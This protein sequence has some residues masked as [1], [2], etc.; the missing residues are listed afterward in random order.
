M[1]NLL[2]LLFLVTLCR[3][4]ATEYFYGTGMGATRSTH[5]PVR[6]YTTPWIS[7]LIASIQANPRVSAQ[8]KDDAIEVVRQLTA[9][10]ALPATRGN[11]ERIVGGSHGSMTISIERDSPVPPS[12]VPGSTFLVDLWLTVPSTVANQAPTIAW[13]SAPA[14]AANGQGYFVSAQGHDPDGNLA[15]VKV[16]KDGQPFAFAEGGNGTDNDSGNPTSD[17]GPK[18]VTFTAQAIDAA[19][20]VSSLISH[21]VTIGAPANQPP[22]VTLLAPAA[23]TITAG[24]VLTIASRATDPDGN[25][26][27]HNLDIQRPAGDWNFQGAFATGEPFQGGPVGSGADST[28]TANFT[29][30]DVGTYAVR[31]AAFDGSNWSHSATIAI[32]V[33]APPPVQYTLATIAGNGG[34]VTPGGVFNTGTVA[35]VTATPDAI[36]DFIGWTGDASG[37]TN[38]LG[39][40]LDRNKV[41]QAGFSF[42]TFT[43]TTSASGGSVTP[44][45]TYPYGTTVTLS[46]SP[47]VTHRFV[48]WA[49]DASGSAA[50]I[51]I[52]MNGPKSVQAVFVTKTAQTITFPAQADQN[53]GTLLALTATASSG[54]PPTF[55]VLSGPAI[56]VNGT[57]TITGPGMI[58]VQAS[59]AG[60]STYLPAPP[61]T[62]AFNAAAPVVLKYTA[63]ARTLLQSGNTPEGIPYVIQTQP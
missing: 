24:T 15:E 51:A 17:N 7:D 52:T 62:R 16:W 41:V 57:L 18:T 45:G 23:Q 10:A 11:Y 36:H 32:T 35:S 9:I 26:T 37:S 1:K 27:N 21:S 53:V 50:T 42:K 33:V 54:L 20:L 14:S 61:V 8:D 30:T 12:H 5:P 31:S 58:T 48:G 60:D 34:S 59:Q 63:V 22:T 46:A 13:T 43:L 38:P 25:L 29:F 40:L 19:G 3:L 39:V 56:M 4:S 6:D 2:L 47:D 44:G 49:G 28:R 55:T